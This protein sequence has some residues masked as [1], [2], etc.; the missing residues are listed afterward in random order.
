MEWYVLARCGA[1]QEG[2]K[3]ERERVKRCRTGNKPV[4]A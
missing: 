3:G 4:S 2:S 1:E